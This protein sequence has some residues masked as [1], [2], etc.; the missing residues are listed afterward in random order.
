MPVPCNADTSTTMVSPP[1]ASGTSPRSESCCS[2]RVASASGRSILLTATMIGTSAAVA[3]SMASIVCGITPS[4]AATTSTTMSVACGAAGAH[5]REGGVAR[6]VDERDPLVVPHD[7]V[8]PDVLGDAAGLSGHHVGLADAVE[9]ERLAVVD[10]P[11]DG[12]DRRPWALVRVL[13]FVFLLEVARQQLGFLLFTGV[14]QADV[15][16]DLG[17]EELDHVVGQRLRRHDHLAL[18]HEEPHDVTRAAVQL[19]PEI[20]RRRS[21]F[22]DDL[23]VGHR[24]RR[25][26]VAGELCRLELLEV[27]PATA[28]AA[29]GWTPSGQPAAPGGRRCTRGSAA[30]GA[31]AESSAAAAGTTGEAAAARSAG[32]TGGPACARRRAASCARGVPTTPGSRGRSGRSPATHT[33]WR[34]D[35]AATGPDRRLGRWWRHGLA[36]RAQGRSRGALLGRWCRW[37]GRCAGCRRG[38]RR[39]GRCGRCCRGGRSCRCGRRGRCCRARA[40][41]RPGRPGRPV[42]PVRQT[43]PIWSMG[44][45]P[46]HPR[47]RRFPARQR[48]MVQSMVRVTA[49]LTWVRQVDQVPFGGRARRS[50]RLPAPSVVRAPP[51]GGRPPFRQVRPAILWACC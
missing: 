15:G 46:G 51:L 10:V 21:A 43:V 18:E 27:A 8:G 22:D 28:G 35:R 32:A 42:R 16:A 41:G 14:D 19:G 7:L 31:P 38:G 26:L 5:G 29:L 49:A 45:R 33:R 37:R 36:T 11:H 44:R 2:T 30:S 9:Q 4:S 23:A 3:W 13:F 47:R 25:R 34:R 20:A 48:A 12:H 24:C 50:G 6:R 17:G 1:H 39:C 40:P